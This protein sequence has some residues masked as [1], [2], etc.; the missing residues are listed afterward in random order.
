MINAENILTAEQ[1]RLAWRCRRGMLELDIILQRFV[2]A[3]FDSLTLAEMQE[4]VGGYIEVVSMKND[5]VMI[6]DE[7]AS[8][9]EKPVNVIAA[10]IASANAPRSRQPSGGI[11]GDVIICERCYLS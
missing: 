5:M 8:I 6:V 7:E 11:A 4:A 2:K 3:Q 9:K 1:R 10:A